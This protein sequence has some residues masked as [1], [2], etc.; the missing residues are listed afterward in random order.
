MFNY[1][2]GP[3]TMPSAVPGVPPPSSSGLVAPPSPPPAVGPPS[4]GAPP[5]AGP[6]PGAGITAPSGPINPGMFPQMPPDPASM[7]YDTETQADGTVLLR[8]KNPDGTPGPV[9]LITKPP[10][11]KASGK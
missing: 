9:V 4:M 1:L 7:Q 5:M 10:A 6:P 8:R 3:P 11:P 2:D